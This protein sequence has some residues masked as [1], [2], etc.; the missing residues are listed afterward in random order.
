MPW[1]RMR[2]DLGGPLSGA[3]HLRLDQQ[4]ATPPCSV[5][6]W[7]AERQC[8]RI[9]DHA[10]HVHRHRAGSDYLRC[11]RWLCV[12][13]TFEPEAG[14]DLCPQC[15]LLFKAWL[16]GRTNSTDGDAA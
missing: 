14:K 3:F 5:C 16:A 13:C 12:H 10:V 1:Y 15:A 7:I 2:Q 8:D 6:G 9:V 11:S 4:D